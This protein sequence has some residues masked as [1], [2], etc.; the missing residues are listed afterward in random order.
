M[1]ARKTQKR[2]KIANEESHYNR[3]P[4]P[5]NAGVRMAHNL[6]PPAKEQEPN[7]VPQWKCGLEGGVLMCGWHVVWVESI[8][9]DSE[10]KEKLQMLVRIFGPIWERRKINLKKSKVVWC[11]SVGRKSISVR[12]NLEWLE[13]VD[14]FRCCG[15]NVAANGVMKKRRD[16]GWKKD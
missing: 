8:F 10:E 12:L 14:Y 3:P 7:R 1:L 2:A 16:S 6:P 9:I 4:H 11:N 13:E 15:M 5:W